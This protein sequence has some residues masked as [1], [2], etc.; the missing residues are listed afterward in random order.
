MP[1][2]NKPQRQMLSPFTI[3]PRTQG[4]AAFSDPASQVQG[5]TEPNLESP[6]QTY[7]RGQLA[8]QTTPQQQAMP[9]QQTSAPT[10]HAG[11]SRN[12]IQALGTPAHPSSEVGV[13]PADVVQGGPGATDPYAQS[14]HQQPTSFANPQVQPTLSPFQMGMA[15][16]VG[17][18]PQP[19]TGSPGTAQPGL[20]SSPATVGPQTHFGPGQQFG[21]TTPFQG[22]GVR[23]PPM[24][25]FDEGESLVIE[26]ELPGVSKKDIELVGRERGLVLEAEG[27]TETEDAEVLASEGGGRIYQREVPLNV[28]IVADDIS[29]TFQNGILKVSLPKK[30]PTAGPESIEIQ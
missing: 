24:T 23:A 19:Q 15:S 29:A 6:G 26:F 2:K 18:D 5:S 20:G 1:Q 9:V 10:A 21:P 28:D 11:F 27:V 13:G 12:P 14:W 8:Q 3:D 25:V 17:V 7:L 4:A 30:E 16:Q 22:A